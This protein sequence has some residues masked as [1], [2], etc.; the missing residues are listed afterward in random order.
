MG[1]VASRTKKIELASGIVNVYSRS[2]TQIAM[3]SA[4]LQNLSSGRFI[5]GIG[6]SSKGIVANWHGME[7]S[8]QIERMKKTISILRSKLDPAD[9]KGDL[10]FLIGN[11]RTPILLAAVH[12]KMVR[13][14][15][16]EADGVV[17]FMRPM[18]KIKSDLREYDTRGKK[19]CANVISCISSNKERA[20]RKVRRTIAFYLTYGTSYRKFIESQENLSCY[21]DVIA[22]IRQE[23]VRG[24]LE[25]ASKLVPAELVR[26]LTI[27]GNVS[28]CR[29]FIEDEY[30]QIKGLYSLAL[31]FN[32]GEESLLESINL[33]TRIPEGK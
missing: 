25:E 28:E 8:H 10:R 13:L 9:T 24:K 5:L 11:L 15:L 19:I 30:R 21:R 18:S 29:R 27:T 2:A 26:E 23:W 33:L 6:S 7:F 3:A 4:T 1:A 22:S 32:S 12:D 14:G 16:E 17:F 31:Q 20:E